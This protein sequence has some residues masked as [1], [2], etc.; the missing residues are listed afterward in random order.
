MRPVFTCGQNTDN[1]FL[2]SIINHLS[3]WIIYIKKTIRVPRP[4]KIYE[5]KTKEKKLYVFKGIGV[6]RLCGLS[7]TGKGLYIFG[8][9]PYFLLWMRWKYALTFWFRW[10]GSG[11]LRVRWEEI[12]R[13]KQISYE[14]VLTNMWHLE[15]EPFKKQ[16]NSF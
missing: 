10:F 3:N 6:T 2:A 4:R 5:W 8:I 11:I 1:A 14:I 12:S 13:K 7:A 15:S 16:K 9:F